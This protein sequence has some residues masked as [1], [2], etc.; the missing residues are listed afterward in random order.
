MAIARFIDKVSLALSHARYVKLHH[1]RGYAAQFFDLITLYRANPTCNIFDYY[2][3]GV[4]AVPRGAPLYKELLGTGA[5]EAFSRSLNP[6]HAVTLAWDKMLFAVMCNAYNIRT[7]EILAI[8]RPTGVLPDFVKHQLTDIA[9]LKAFLQREKGPFFIKPA[10]GSL[11]QG[12]FYIAAVDKN[13][14]HVYDKKGNLVSFEDFHTKTIGMKG[15][16]HYN[17]NAGILLQR[18]VI[19]HPA[20]TEF[21]QTDT[22]SGLRILVINTGEGPYIHRAI[23]KI[24][25]PGNISDNF[26]K[27]KHGNMVAQIDLE[28]GQVSSAVN[29]Y[30]PATKLHQKHPV[31]ENDFSGFTLPLWQ[32]VKA[33]VLRASSVVFGMGAMHWD[34]IISQDG[35]LFLELNDIGSTEFLQL[36]GKGLIDTELKQKMQ[37]MALLQEGSAFARFISK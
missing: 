23:W 10:K 16:F 29:G 31:S 8:Y 7:T 26:S 22:P 14:E 15:A 2:K 4:F 9:Q 12:T 13:C 20:I 28:T 5:L 21:T 18:P 1:Q 3:Y 30:W 6:R 19:Q 25:A 37:Q 36:H 33:E 24:I 27:G 34:L 32:Q 35:A 11:G 17:A